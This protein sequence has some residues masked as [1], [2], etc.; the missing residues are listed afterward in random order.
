MV[1]A[2]RSP[3]F[4][5]S[6]RDLYHWKVTHGRSWRLHEVV[7]GRGG[8]TLPDELSDGAVAEGL[9]CLYELSERIPW[10]TPSELL[11][12]LVRERMVMELALVGDDSRDVWRR[13]RFVVD[14]ARAWSDAG[15]HGVRRYL[16]WTRLQ[17]DDGRFVAET[18]LPETDHDGRAHHD[19]ARGQG[20]A[21]PDH[22]RLR[23]QQYRPTGG[24]QAGGVDH[25]R[26]DAQRQ[27]RPRVPAVRPDRRSDERRRASRGCSTSRA[28]G[29]W[30]TWLCRCTAP[31]RVNRSAAWALAD[32]QRRCRPPPVRGHPGGAR[33]C[34]RADPASGVGRRDA[35]V[36]DLEQHAGR[37]IRPAALSATT[38]AARLRPANPTRPPAKTRSI[39]TC[40]PGNEAATARPWVAPCMPCCSSPICST[41]HDIAA[42][43][44]AQ[45]AAE[46][47]FDSE[48]TIERLARSALQAP[49]GGR[50]CTW[51]A[52]ARVVRG[53][54]SRRTSV[55]EG[56]ID[57][58]GARSRAWPAGGRLQDRPDAPG[59]DRDQRLR[60]TATSW[61]PTAWPSSSYSARPIAGGV[62]VM[63][64]TSGAAEQVEVAGWAALCRD[65][66]R[67]SW[68]TTAETSRASRWVTSVCPCGQ[69]PRDGAFAPET[70][71]QLLQ[72]HQQ[73]QP[74]E[75]I[76]QR[77]HQRG[78]Q[79]ARVAA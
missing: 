16:L 34:R 62:L 42:L 66:A 74:A 10:S 75:G 47:V 35:V 30:I 70:E 20:A 60:A 55:V 3:L 56:Y 31:R 5:C 51:A 6:D 78:A 15:G 2:L 24:W 76:Q 4:G 33:S 77:I 14:Q 8:E 12:W 53:R 26:L 58:L 79:V 46:G 48:R 69:G 61:R 13:V 19:R 71:Q 23:P 9:R 45:A 25:R 68:L 50:G 37:S 65:S 64:R 21:V 32:G 41:A 1:S 17:G 39:S 63:C 49:V 44:A 29:R 52:L 7:A 38:L 11:A 43:A 36:A 73:H 57:L 27:E 40:R 18:V 54:A 67:P 22:H 28:P 59:A 72:Q